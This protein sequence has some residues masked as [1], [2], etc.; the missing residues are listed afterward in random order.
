MTLY[1]NQAFLQSGLFEDFKKV[2]MP[3]MPGFFILTEHFENMSQRS[4]K[5][6][7]LAFNIGFSK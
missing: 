6:F 7:C 2:G 4:R 5:A 3:D 1:G